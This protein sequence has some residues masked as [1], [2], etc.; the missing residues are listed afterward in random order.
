LTYRGHVHHAFAK[1]WLDALPEDTRLCFCRFTQLGFLR[2]LTTSAVMGERVLTQSAAWKI[3]DEWLEVGH[4]TFVEEPP[5]LESVFR[6][7]SK[8]GQPEPKAWADSYVSAFAEASR[9]PLV[10]FDQVLQ[11]KTKRAVL[12]KP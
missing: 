3:Y 9:L 7:L 6:S 11:R 12:L 10:T 5:A 2:L 1:R 8:S 4:A